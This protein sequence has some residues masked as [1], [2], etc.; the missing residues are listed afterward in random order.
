MRKDPAGLK[1]DYE[2]ASGKG[3]GGRRHRRSSGGRCKKH[4]K[5]TWRHGFI[6]RRREALLEIGEKLKL[7]EEETKTGRKRDQGL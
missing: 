5:K 1:A 2:A 6:R 4:G 7:L 3:I